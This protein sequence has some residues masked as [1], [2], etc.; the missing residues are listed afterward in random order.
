MFHVIRKLLQFL[1]G[2]T[3]QRWEPTALC[4]GRDS[5]RHSGQNPVPR[6]CH[7]A[8]C[9]S[10]TTRSYNSPVAERH[11]AEGVGR[12]RADQDRDLVVLLKIYEFRDRFSSI[13]PPP[14][15]LRHKYGWAQDRGKELPSNTSPG[16]S[17]ENASASTPPCSRR[18]RVRRK[19][20]VEVVRDTA[21]IG[22]ANPSRWLAHSSLSPDNSCSSRSAEIR[23][24]TRFRRALSRF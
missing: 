6:S 14:A 19:P 4:N 15:S 17:A 24:H 7:K 1:I 10:D 3:V 5:D 11:V 20:R 2:S 8:S 21:D 22:F 23:I 16:H 18:P 13:R 12:I 9:T